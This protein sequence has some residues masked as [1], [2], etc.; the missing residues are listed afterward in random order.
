MEKTIKLSIKILIVLCCV[1]VALGTALLLGGTDAQTGYAFSGVEIK[2]QYMVEDILEI[3]DGKFNIDNKDYSAEKVVY[4]PNGDVK[5]TSVLR[6]VDTGNYTIEYRVEKDGK[7]YSKTY[8]TNAVKSLYSVS[9]GV[10][11]V[12]YKL[13]DSQYKTGISGLA[14]ELAKGNTFNFN[15]VINLNELKG[16]DIISLFVLPKTYGRRDITDIKLYL[17]DAYN[18]S[19]QVVIQMN[20]VNSKGVQAT[21][22]WNVNAGMVFVGL[23]EYMMYGYRTESNGSAAYE[24]HSTTY[25]YG[26]ESAFSFSGSTDVKDCKTENCVVGKQFFTVQIDLESGKVFAG[27]NGNAQRYNYGSEM[28]ANLNDR[29]VFSN[30]W[31]GFTTG[32]V[33]LSVKC[34]G[35]I[36]NSASL[37][38]NKIGNEDLTELTD[39]GVVSPKISVD[40]GGYSENNLP[41][42]KVGTKYK[43]FDAVMSDYYNTNK[44]VEPR[45][46][47][48]YNSPL[49]REVEVV[50]GAFVPDRTGKY[51]IVYKVVDVFGNCTQ[52]CYVVDAKSDFTMSA[53]FNSGYQTVGVA[54]AKVDVATLNVL[55]ASGYVDVSVAALLWNEKTDIDGYKFVPE[56]SGEYTIKYTVIDY[57]G[58]KVELSYQLNVSK[59]DIPVMFKAGNLPKY[60]MEDKQ[61]VLPE[62]DMRDLSVAGSSTSLKST[63]TVVDGNGTK[64]ISS[65]RK[66]TPKA[67]ANGKTSITY[68]ATSESGQTL[69]LPTFVIP[70]I[71]VKNDLGIDITK[72]FITEGNVNVDVDSSGVTYSGENDFS[73]EFIKPVLADTFVLMTSVSVINEYATTSGIYKIK[74]VDSIDSDQSIE[75]TIEKRVGVLIIYVNGVRY[76]SQ[77]NYDKTIMSSGMVTVEYKQKTLYFND[78]EIVLPVSTY[79]DGKEFNGFTSGYVCFTLE[80]VDIQGPNAIKISQVNNQPVR[81]IIRNDAVLPEIALVNDVKRTVEL[82]D[83]ITLSN[84]FACDVLDNNT[85]LSLTVKNPDG[86][87]AKSKDGI[88][89]NNVVPAAYNIEVEEYGIYTAE[90]VAVDGNG[91]KYVYTVNI[92]SVDLIPPEIIINEDIESTAEEGDEIYVP[93]ATI[94]DNVKGNYRLQIYICSPLNVYT[95]YNSNNTYEF[96]EVGEWKIIY[97]AYDANENETVK[98]FT[99]KVID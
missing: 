78:S 59:Y 15:K 81:K 91:C 68:S 90:Y 92:A 96:N 2:T 33:Y 21:S 27:S 20:A 51:T 85:S 76:V 63:I 56:K 71:S 23:N 72:Y 3:P 75:I 88:T 35:Y 26:Y 6:F 37:M 31:Q 93:Q 54:G 39:N 10:S 29:S 66:Y 98:T 45:V 64:T 34:D 9:S 84:A 44:V 53:S 28:A 77:I 60:F 55:D 4:Y 7:L 94:T 12:Q 65:D 22:A 11:S 50:D 17:T 24:K 41:I 99:V 61:Y 57:L 49:Y 97:V 46:F 43:L 8:E 52:K 80:G 95:L 48:N 70:V 87:L 83:I 73:F 14:V 30:G 82:G 5:K 47:F 86:T 74:V 89:L 1:F 62:F 69:T 16:E 25:R 18:K 67:D 58:Q 32:E 19:N 38:I 13:D 36:N 40:L 42:A 79:L